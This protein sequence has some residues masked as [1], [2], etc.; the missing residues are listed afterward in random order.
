MQAQLAGAFSKPGLLVRLSEMSDG[1]RTCQPGRATPHPNVQPGPTTRQTPFSG[2]GDV[3]LSGHT[4][5]K[6]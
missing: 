4:V 6:F 1:N 3:P 5:N 2:R